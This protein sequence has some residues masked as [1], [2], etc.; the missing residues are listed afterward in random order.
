MTGDPEPRAPVPT[1]P[2]VATW[3]AGNYTLRGLS[4]VNVV[5]GKNG[6]GKSTLLK[7][8][9]QHLSGAELGR[10][11]YVTPER[12]GVLVYEAGIEQNIISNPTWIA[13]TR[14]VNQLRS[15]SSKARH[16]S[17]DLS[18]AY[19]ARA[20]DAK[21]PISARTSSNSPASSTISRSVVMSRLLSSLTE[22]PAVRL[23]PIAS[24]AVSQSSS[25]SE[26]K[27]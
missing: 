12:G 8:L 22:L 1:L 5:L 14:R 25:R 13:E 2:P 23:R 4:H 11:K 7:A 21:S 19:C 10:K 16:S 26:S 6:C 17:G 18:Y 24:V 3:T 15:S 20:R 9:D 27:C